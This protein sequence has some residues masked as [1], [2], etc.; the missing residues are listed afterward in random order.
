MAE[1]CDRIQAVDK[2]W[3]DLCSILPKE[4]TEGY[5]YWADTDN[6]IMSASPEEIAQTIFFLSQDAP[7][8]LTGQ[9]IGVNGGSV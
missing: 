4:P 3:R 1:I 8:Y 7:A 6:Q 9:V 5:T 2:L